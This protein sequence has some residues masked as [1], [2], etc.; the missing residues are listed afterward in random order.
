[1]TRKNGEGRRRYRPRLAVAALRQ[2][3]AVLRAV[4]NGV[5]ESI[6]VFKPDGTVIMGNAT[7]KSRWANPERDILGHN[8]MEFTA[9]EVAM[10]RMEVLQRVVATGKVVEFSDERDGMHFQHTFCPVLDEH[11]RTILVATFSRDVTATRKADADLLAT[12]AELERSNRELAQFAH[13]SSHDIQEP[14]RMIQAYS[15][16]FG[17]RYGEVLDERG[18]KYLAQIRQAASGMSGLVRGLLEYSQVGAGS[19]RVPVLGEEALAAAL[20]NLGAA[21]G[22][23]GAQV[24]WD[25]LPMVQA[26]PLLFTQLLQNLIGNAI[27]FRRPGLPPRVRIGC[28]PEGGHWRL[29]VE[30]NGI[31]IDPVFQDKVFLIFQRLHGRD[32][33]PG[34]GVGLAICKKIVDQ[35]GGVIGFE[36]NRDGG[37]SFWF[38]WPR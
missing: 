4:L 22:E 12:I 8:F 31:G 3:E 5:Q 21:I 9:P 26:D 7:G 32:E 18:R 19:R 11:G 24:S 34:T 13:L 36:P 29:Q 23:S 6:W 15:D 2:S 17:E 27:K 14:L 28:R 16:L 10:V 30:D 35:H 25:P 1:M 37:C 38:T 20:A 33:F